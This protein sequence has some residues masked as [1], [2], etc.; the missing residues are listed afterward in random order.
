MSLVGLRGMMAQTL[1]SPLSIGY[2]ECDICDK[3]CFL[4]KH[5][6][7]VICKEC[8][9]RLKSVPLKGRFVSG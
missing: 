5:G 4:Y 3:E 1:G 6:I 9:E 7:L 2:G 8:K